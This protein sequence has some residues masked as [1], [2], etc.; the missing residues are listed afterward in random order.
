MNAPRLFAPRLTARKTAWLTLSLLL[1]AAALPPGAPAAVSVLTFHNDL[2]RTGQ[3]LNETTLTP[4]NVNTNTFG[5]VFAFLVDGYIYGQPLILTNVAVAGKGTHNVVFVVTEHDSVYA[6]DAD[7]GAGANAAPLWQTNFLNPAAGITTLPNTD[8]KSTDIVPE[9]GITSTPVIDP[10]TGTIYVEA[11]TKEVSGGVTSY[12]HRLH[13]LDVTSGA[14]KFGGPIVIAKTAYDGTTY[15]Y[16]SGPSVAGTGDGN[17]GGVVT[18]NALRQL[19]RPGLV[20]L[21]GVLYIAYAS[22]GDNGPYHGWV[23]AYNAQTLALV[24][25]YNTSANGGL[26]GIWQS[27]GPPAADASGYLYFETGNGTFNTNYPSPNTYSLGDSFVKLSTNGLA[28]IDYF[29]PFNQAALSS[30]DNDLGSGGPVV[31]PDSVGSLAHPHLLVGCGKEGK[32]YLLDRDNLGHFN[33]NNDNQIVQELTNA[34]GGTWSLPAYFNNQIY[35]QGVNDVLKAFT[36]ASGLVVTTPSSLASGKFG[37]PGATPS[38]SANGALNAIVWTLQTS[39][40]ASSGPGILHAYNASDVS[41][42]LYNSTQAAKDTAGGSVKFTLPTVANGKVYVPGE[43]GLTVFGLTPATNAYLKSFAGLLSGFV[44]TLSDNGPA[45][46]TNIAQVLL[47][48]TNDVTSLATHS[49]AAPLTTV[50]YAQ[51]ARFT[52][53][54]V[55][56]AAITWVDSFNATNSWSTLFTVPQFVAFPTNF[57][58]PLSA[59]DTTRVGLYVRPFQWRQANPNQMWWTDEA[60]QGYHGTNIVGAALASSDA[61]GLYWDGPMGLIGGTSGATPFFSGD[62]DFS[63]FGIGANPPSGGSFNIRYATYDHSGLEMYGYVYFPTSGVYNMVIGSDDSFQLSVGVDPRDR[64]GQVL[65]FNNGARVPS[66]TS[67][68]A[69]GTDLRPVVVDTPGVYPIRLTY[70]NGAGGAAFEWYYCQFPN[71]DSTPYNGAFLVNDTNNISTAAAQGVAVILTYRA[72]NGSVPTGPYVSKVNPTRNSQDA[73]YYTPMVVDLTDG[74]SAGLAVNAATVG[75]YNYFVN[76]SLVYVT[77]HFTFSAAKVGSVTQVRETDTPAWFSG[78]Y[79]N[80]LTFNDMSGKSYAYTWP[81]SVIGGRVGGGVAA[82]ADVT[83]TA[84][85]FTLTTPPGATVDTTKPGFRVKSW[86]SPAEGPNH[87]AWSD[88][89]LEGLHEQD[90]SDKSTTNVGP[91]IWS[92]NNLIDFRYSMSAGG[93][94]TTG[95][96]G[97][98]NYDRTNLSQFGIGTPAVQAHVPYLR[99]TNNTAEESSALDI[100]AWLVFP[101]AGN[102]IMYINSDDGFRLE[103]PMG[104]PFGKLGQTPLNY[105]LAADVGRGMAGAAGG[106]QTGGNYI[107]FTIPSPGAYPFRLVYFNG[108]TDSGLEWSIYQKMGDGSVFRVP[109]NDADTDFTGYIPGT[110]VIKAYLTVT[111]G[112][113]PAPYVSYVNPVPNAQDIFRWQPIVIE[114]TDGTAPNTVNG[115]S[116]TLKVDGAAVTLSVTT[117]A[118]GVTR[119]ATAYAPYAPW[120]NGNHTNV[121]TFSDN[122]GHSYTNTWSFS[123]MSQ[124]PTAITT[125]TNGV[126]LAAVDTTQ[127]GFRVKA[128]QTVTAIG[129]IDPAERSFLGLNG[130]NIATNRPGGVPPAYYVWNKVVDF[131]DNLAFNAGSGEFRYNFSFSNAFGIM[132]NGGGG[133]ENN[134]T[135][136]FAGWMVFPQA[137]LYMMTVNSDDGFKLSSPA[138]INPFSEAGQ[139]ISWFDGGRGNNG[140]NANP[141]AGGSTTPGVFYVPT[142]GAYPIRLLWWNGGGGLNLEWTVWEYQANGTLRREQVGDDDAIIKVY[143]SLTNPPAPFVLA[144]LPTPNNVA[145]G[146][147]QLNF[148]P[149]NGSTTPIQVSQDYNFFLQDGASPV[150]TNTIQLWL[151]GYSQPIIVTNPAA[152]ISQVTRQAANATFW[153]SGQFG[154][155]L[156][157]YQDMAGNSY[158]QFVENVTTPFWGTLSNHYYA[159]GAGDTNKFGFKARTYQV[160]PA[161]TPYHTNVVTIG[162]TIP[163]RIHVAEQILAGMWGPNVANLAGATDGGYFD[164]FGSGKTNGVIN[165][166]GQVPA[167]AGDFQ[168]PTWPDQQFPGLPGLGPTLVNNDRS[169]SVALEF[170][171]YVEFPTNGTYILGVASD[172][173]FRLTHNLT[174]DFAPPLNKGALIVNSPV[175]V[176]GAKATCQNGTFVPITSLPITNPITG[177]LVLVNGLGFGSTNA[178]EGCAIA[179]AGALVGNIALI[180]QSIGGNCSF[181]QQIDNAYQAGARAVVFVRNTLTNDAWF[182]QETTLVTPL[183][184][185]PAVQISLDDGNA[186]AA[187]LPSPGVNVTITTFDYT[188][189]PPPAESPLGEADQGKGAGDVLFPVVVN[190]PGLYPLRLVYWNGGGNV[191]CEFF[192]LTVSS[193]TGTNRTLV[194]DQTATNGPALNGGGLRAFAG[195]G[196]LYATADAVNVSIHFNPNST[197]QSSP[198]LITWSDVTPPP[199]NPLVIPIGSAGAEKFYR[200]RVVEIP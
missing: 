146:A 31:L 26:A 2:A 142:A 82:A 14:E 3:N 12:V 78:Q 18:F 148:G 76:A 122:G 114:L 81:F 178:N 19:N 198:D 192:T 52:A 124:T 151:N 145:G 187:S 69:L 177:N 89:Q 75:F 11:K 35:Y 135:L 44:F 64:L 84:I 191:S 194:N 157:T 24:A 147:P 113:A 193:I 7:S 28:V 156:V 97:E 73:V 37:F 53:G 6:F 61:G 5:K 8:V 111:G 109:V 168:S 88:E 196:G 15:T 160:D 107:P 150:N 169:N 121:L 54:S 70:E 103:N 92:W 149:G 63:V 134:C 20:L 123:V 167:Q 127:P 25:A 138:G 49:Y 94:L 173:G 133:N 40:Y 22:H 13:A 47:D 161:F 140:A 117:P 105:I 159:L 65:W 155:L 46:V 171:A 182:P 137:G 106:V 87:S 1:G 80:V 71:G 95:A 136:Q 79:T 98:W 126:P 184:P 175:S 131:A 165:F 162:T 130:P 38:I 199:A 60:F 197:L 29:T 112:D 154:P 30:A 86:Q 172:D 23:L 104:T 4:V 139:S 77:N 56:A 144:M 62:T 185:I 152:G 43:Y 16:V 200:T 143:Q 9:I 128:Y 118:A 50:S 170:R 190:N 189:N 57:V 125:L 186:L 153:P 33:P 179:N 68:P 93:V 48:A 176:A 183:M 72:A 51:A 90:F 39:A 132:T 174:N 58:L 158:T 129:N 45:V 181:Q 21:N 34:V 85:T 188:V 115:G 10:S 41:L 55:H 163:N 120:G 91:G 42:E 195:L 83:N 102:Y 27:G 108:G 164:V 99:F 119:L 66:A 96:G 101:A 36:L 32:I 59:V 67:P 17:V 74:S 166:N 116:A 100:A 141:L 180:Y 110:S